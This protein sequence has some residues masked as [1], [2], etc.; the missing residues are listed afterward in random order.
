MVFRLLGVLLVGLFLSACAGADYPGFVDA[1]VEVTTG[2]DLQGGLDAY[3][4]QQGAENRAGSDN[5]QAEPQSIQRAAAMPPT[6]AVRTSA[7]PNGNA[8]GN[9]SQWAA[10]VV[11]A[12]SRAATG[13]STDA[14]DNSRR[15]ITSQLVRLGFEQR[16][17]SQFSM[18][19]ARYNENGLVE[20]SF[21]NIEQ[22][23]RRSRRRADEGCLVFLTSHGYP[24]GLAVGASEIILPAQMDQLLVDQCGD[25]P[26]IL[27]VSSCYSGVFAQ[28]D[29][30]R[31]NRF[32]MTAARSDRTSFGCGEGQRYPYFDAC[33]LETF[34]GAGDWIELA[35]GTRSCVVGREQAGNL[36][37]PSSP[38]I[39]VGPE[40]REILLNPFQSTDYY[41]PPTPGS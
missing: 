18:R 8:S 14:F 36:S 25:D 11:A 9:F 28:G 24:T 33:L 1:T 10:I 37:P 3:N 15:D 30:V 38:Q 21:E 22:G 35:R 20:T 26:T 27:I 39:Y 12:D 5:Q 6:A 17:I 23:L 34:P 4:R 29:M 7:R 13:A 41:G 16:N 32:I 31:A 19:P 2:V 40:I